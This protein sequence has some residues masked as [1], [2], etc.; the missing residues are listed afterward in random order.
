MM[1]GVA[2]FGLL[3]R[4]KSKGTFAKSLV[5]LRGSAPGFAS[6]NWIAA[7]RY[8]ITCSGGK[9]ASLG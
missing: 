9:L 7:V 6:L 3:G 4:Y 1:L 2:P 5:A 8:L